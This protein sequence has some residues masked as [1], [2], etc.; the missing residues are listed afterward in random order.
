MSNVVNHPAAA[1]M[2]EAKKEREIADT[3][4]A[5]ALQE[6]IFTA[7]RA[8]YDYLDRNGLFYDAERELV[9]ASALRVIC[10]MC[11]SVGIIL[12]DGAIDRRYGDGE[13]PDPFGTGLNPT[14]P[15]SKSRRS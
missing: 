14:R 4:E 1:L 10:D 13:D 9:R 8:Y 7:V 2:T 15:Q 5:Q 11:G 6:A 12:D 3:T